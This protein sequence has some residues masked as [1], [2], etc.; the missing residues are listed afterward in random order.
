MPST[1]AQSGTRT[2]STKLLSIYHLLLSLIRLHR[3]FSPLRAQR[4]ILVY[5][6]RCTWGEER[7][8][9]KNTSEATEMKVTSILQSTAKDIWARRNLRYGISS[10]N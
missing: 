6:T 8:F 3:A 9:E 1:R 4:M 2:Y 10:L 5:L 7:L